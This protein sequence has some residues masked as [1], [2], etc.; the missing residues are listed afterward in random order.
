MA[1][2]HPSDPLEVLLEVL[3]AVPIAIRNGDCAVVRAQQRRHAQRQPPG[4]LSLRII[5]QLMCKRAVFSLIC[6]SQ[7]GISCLQC[8]CANAVHA[9]WLGHASRHCRGSQACNFVLLHS[10]GLADLLTIVT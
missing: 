1:A 4:Q 7:V 2:H 10:Q 9:Q 6:M 8:V 3:V 5:Q